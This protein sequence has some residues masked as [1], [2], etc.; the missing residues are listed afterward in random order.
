[1]ENH[2]Y[3][4][5]IIGSGMAALQCAIHASVTKKV[6]LITKTDVRSCNTYLAQGGVAVAYAA[7]DSSESHKEDT[8]VAGRFHNREQAVSILVE[9]GFYAVDELV[10]EG[11][12]FDRDAQGNLM[13]GL[14]G[15]HSHR[16]ILHSSGDSTGRKLFE[17]LWHKVQASPVE[18]LENHRAQELL[19]SEKG[20][21]IGVATKDMNGRV[22]LFYASHTVL[23]SGGCGQLYPYTTNHENACGDGFALALHAGAVLK[24]MEFMQF[25]PT[26]LYGNGGVKGLISEAVRGE[27]GILVDENRMRIMQGIHPLEDLAPRHLVSQTIFSHMAEGHAVYLDIS[28]VEN[29]DGKFPAIAA[30]CR[31]N[32]VDWR[33]GLLPVA[34]AS[35]FMMGGV[36]VDARGATNIP[37]LYA[38][39]EVACTGVHGANR[40]ASNSL[41]EGLVFGKKAGMAIA[42]APPQ[43]V[44]AL[45]LRKKKQPGKKNLPDLLDLKQM[46][47]RYA[48]IS[49]S[50]EGLGELFR[51]LR[52]F[53]VE[54]LLEGGLLEFNDSELTTVFM[55]LTAWCIAVGADT[56]TESRGAHLRSDYPEEDPRWQGVSCTVDLFAKKGRIIHE[57]VKA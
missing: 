46:M 20:S 21:C 26:G 6:L 19:I 24:D 18:C 8:M 9:D 37:G 32:G 49:R 15:A 17:F 56:R 30:L 4:V 27:G 44:A 1:M 13:Y 2:E 43:K 33:E 3:D 51:Y 45:P 57:F 14:E 39:G 25:H 52:Q 12:D 11:M 36:E 42:E 53:D 22:H 28:A 35:H 5:L 38:V 10:Q 40:L 16:R 31:R 41:L 47:F 7:G 48:G 23:A 34:P 29:F 54:S 55:L 50:A